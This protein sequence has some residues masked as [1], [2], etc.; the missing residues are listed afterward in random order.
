MRNTLQFSKQPKLYRFTHNNTTEF[1][2]SSFKTKIKL[3]SKRIT[4][5]IT[6][7]EIHSEKRNAIKPSKANKSSHRNTK[8]FK[9]KKG[10]PEYK[11]QIK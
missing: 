10:K 3:A 1:P 9:I 2:E 11:K 6:E 7:D 8:T 4:H 5:S